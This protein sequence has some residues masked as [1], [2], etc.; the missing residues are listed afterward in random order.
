MKI[1]V[2][3]VHLVTSTQKCCHEKALGLLVVISKTVAFG[4]FWSVCMQ[5]AFFSIYS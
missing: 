3:T 2:G 5:N 4:T 1:Q